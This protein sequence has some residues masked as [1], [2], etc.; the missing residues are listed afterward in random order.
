MVGILLA[1]TT[2]SLVILFH[3]Y[4]TVKFMLHKCPFS[5]PQ[6]HTFRGPRRIRGRLKKPHTVEHLD[7]EITGAPADPGWSLGWDQ[8]ILAAG[9]V[10]DRAPIRQRP[11]NQ[12]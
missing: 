8:G 12:Q 11:L 4:S 10:A 7:L 1:K 9:G 6:L 5:D 3:L 2:D